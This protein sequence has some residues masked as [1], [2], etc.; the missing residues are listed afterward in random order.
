MSQWTLISHVKNRLE[1]KWNRGDFLAMLVS[2]EPFIPLRI[3]LAHPSPSEWGL[4]F[5]AVRE[6]VAGWAAP[7][8]RKENSSFLIEWKE[9]VSRSLG[10]N[11]IPVAICFNR[12]E[13]IFSFIGK[14]KEALRFSNRYREITGLFP[15]L[16]HLLVQRAMDVLAHDPVWP[17]LLAILSF[18]KK[19]PRPRIY[20]RQMDI[21]GVD[22]KFVE[23]HKQW[24]ER[25]LDPVLS[26]SEEGEGKDV[27]SPMTFEQRFGFLSKPVRV[28]FRI[29]DPAS[30]LKGLS[31]LEVPIEAFMGLTCDVE[32]V[33]IVENEING[34][35]FPFFPRSMVIFGLGYGLSAL[36]G[37]S[38]LKERAIWYWGDI[39]THGFAMLNQIRRAFG[40]VRSFLMDEETLL[41]HRA[42]WGTEKTP[43]IRELPCL[44]PEE[45]YLYQG[46]IHHRYA[47]ALR[48]EQEHIRFS[49]VQKV[50]KQIGG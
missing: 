43:A 48:L 41:S 17:E 27:F 12:L 5:D 40:D 28:R 36:S 33:F 13:D 1:K 26:G 14:K 10:R 24:L 25:L 22:T 3:P 32:T 37:V 6:W 46:L 2:D 42:I 45:T 16:K 19:N 21:A 31:D 50:L 34:L 44:T 29:L 39:D 38:W 23:R 4:Q 49:M 30:Y 35:A 9:I 18:L 20:I 15:E 8:A 7:L 47:Q 11:K